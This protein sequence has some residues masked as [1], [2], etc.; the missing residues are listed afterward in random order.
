MI[1]I[2]TEYNKDKKLLL[3]SYAINDK[4]ALVVK[5]HFIETILMLLDYNLP[6]IGHNIK[7][8]VYVIYKNTGILLKNVVCTMVMAQIITNG[9]KYKVGLDNVVKDLLGI[10]LNKELRN[11]FITME[12]TVGISEE[13]LEYSRKDAEY[14]LPIYKQMYKVIRERNQLQA[15]EIENKIIPVLVKMES[16][17]IFIDRTKV[18]V[19]KNTL[20]EELR[21]LAENCYKALSVLGFE[22]VTKEYKTTKYKT[23]TNTR[24]ITYKQLLLSSSKQITDLF[25]FFNIPLPEKYGKSTTDYKLLEKFIADNPEHFL[26]PFL[27]EF[28][29]YKQMFHLMQSFVLPLADKTIKYSSKL[30]YTGTFYKSNSTT[31]GRLSSSKGGDSWRVNVF[32][33][34]ARSEYGKFIKQCF[35]ADENKVIISSDLEAAEMRLGAA[36]ANDKNLLASFNLGLDIHSMV[37][38]RAYNVINNA[39][40]EWTQKEHSKGHYHN[41]VSHRDR[42]KTLFYS[43]LNGA[44]TPKVAEIYGVNNET[45]VKLYNEV[46]QVLEGLQEFMQFQYKFALSNNYVES[47]GITNRR[48]YNKKWSELVNF[49]WQSTNADAIKIALIRLDKY[50]TENNL[51]C[52]IVNSVY[53]SV[54]VEVPKLNGYDEIMTEPD[55]DE[56]K[57]KLRVLY[58]DYKWIPK[59]IAKAISLFLNNK[60]P[61]TSDYNIGNCWQ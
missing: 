39:N 52:R 19:L 11:D 29:K 35:V 10:K 30:N 44:Q 26:K 9:T 47:N 7:A 12:S 59:I 17:P 36:V 34:P 28:I 2:D 4:P 3:L 22:C 55:S 61:G 49:Y 46:M 51:N 20:K 42:A 5:S 58:K 31:T 15:L 38:S 33:I 25:A 32:N 21:K 16:N 60:L 41:G 13:L 53:D 27:I 50:I 6:F 57:E 8:D 23:Q 18:N 43:L 24:K 54:F 56:R 1:S 48:R 14:L 40:T 45:A 37:A